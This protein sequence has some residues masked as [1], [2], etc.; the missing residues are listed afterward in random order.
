MVSEQQEFVY[1]PEYLLLSNEPDTGYLDIQ[2]AGNSLYYEAA[3]Y[4]VAMQK[5][6]NKYMVYS[7]DTNEAVELSL[8]MSEGHKI[9]T[10]TADKDGNI[11]TIE[12]SV[13]E[14]AMGWTSVGKWFLCKYSAGGN[15]QYEH[16]ITQIMEADEN[17]Y[18]PGGIAVDDQGRLYM[19]SDS[20]VRLFDAEGN[21]QGSI[22]LQDAWTR[23]IGTGRDGKV[24]ISYYDTNSQTE[25]LALSEIDFDNKKLGAAY[26]DFPDL[27][28]SDRLTPGPENTFLRNDG[29]KVYVYDL[30]TQTSVELFS[31]MDC[32]INGTYA[33][34]VGIG[35][36]GKLVALVSDWNTQKTEI[37]Y[38]TKTAA[39]EL[40][41]KIEVTIGSLYDN[42]DLRDAVLYFNK[43]SDTYRIEIKTYTEEGGSW[44]DGLAALNN[45]ILSDSDCPD[46][47]NL[48]NLNVEQLAAK[49]ALEDLNPYLDKSSVIGREDYFENIINGY[50][51]GGKLVCI[52][53]S[54]ELST[55]AGKTSDVGPEMGWTLEEIMTYLEE[56]PGASLF[57]GYTRDDMAY[58]LLSYKQN[59][60]VD[61][62]N[63]KCRF[64]SDEFKNLL[65]FI[66][67]FPE[68]HN[69]GADDRSTP[70]KLQSGDVLLNP[71]SIYN[72]HCMQDVVM[73]NEPV[74]FIGYP[75]EGGNS[76]CYL[77]GREMYAITSK[78]DN[79]DGAW[80]F[81]EHYLTN[82]SAINVQSK[83]STNKQFM[84]EMITERTKVVYVLDENGQPLQDENGEPI[85]RDGG[86]AIVF[87]D[88]EYTYHIPTPEEAG[89]LKKLIYVAVPVA[90]SDY[91][92]TNIINEEA[93]AYYE[94]QKSVD[95]VAEI[96]QN[97]IQIYVNENR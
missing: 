41:E 76:G 30:E 47:L 43:Y 91:E 2:M 95:D 87:D 46:I 15:V 50:T 68:E 16:E 20:M 67:L 59:T 9:R 37:V 12:F 70:I 73:F 34:Y 4:D 26:A 49:G 21:S 18:Y 52:P 14:E 97:R 42:S 5:Q 63:G 8:Q 81:I 58:M 92:I 61:W 90:S 78:S 31:W 82:T 17:N 48:S 7:L 22:T 44:K 55:I 89:R 60:F 24:Y 36:D 66:N 74:T 72:L 69:G 85:P 39:S 38:L 51:L 13:V 80:A 56:N 3:H 45:D 96:I 79:K 83:L 6:E 32:Y 71:I 19:I 35:E 93:A 75:N 25:S 23:E 94:G 57:D 1:V 77:I 29:S 40:P 11:Y 64:D 84:E 54:F 88:W 10:F 53:G 62:E 33:N 86:G 28:N 27:E 65:T